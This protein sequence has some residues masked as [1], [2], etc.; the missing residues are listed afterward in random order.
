MPI[1]PFRLSRVPVSLEQDATMA[2]AI[3]LVEWEPTMQAQF[4]ENM[5]TTRGGQRRLADPY[6]I[7]V[8]GVKFFVLKNRNGSTG[9]SKEIKWDK[10]TN[11]YSPLVIAPGANA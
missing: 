1:R 9:K 3:R 7:R 8:V 4:E 11:T 10:A 2:L 5:I 6:D